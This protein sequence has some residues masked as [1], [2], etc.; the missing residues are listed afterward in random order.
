M[1][2]TVKREIL[3]D[4]TTLKVGD[5]VKVR[6]TIEADQDYD[7]VQIVDK[8]AVCMEPVDII[9]GYRN[10]CYQVKKDN[11]TQYYF[12]RLRKGTTTIETEYYIDRAGQYETG[13]CTAQCAYSP[14]FSARAA[15]ITVDVE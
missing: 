10:G 4:N 12:T 8:R 6:I 13:T 7:F 2:M 11:V 1:G 15:S 9:S 5:K 14:A 3:N